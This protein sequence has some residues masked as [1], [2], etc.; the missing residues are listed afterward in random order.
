[1]LNWSVQII[2]RDRVIPCRTGHNFLLTKLHW[3]FTK[4]GLVWHKAKST[5][6]QEKL[7]LIGLT[8]YKVLSNY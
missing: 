1:M 3:Y 2:G 6:N 5:G 8:L 4:L 7:K